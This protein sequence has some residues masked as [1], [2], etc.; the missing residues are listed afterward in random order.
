MLLPEVDLNKVLGV[1]TKN[2]SITML[3]PEVH[4]LPKLRINLVRL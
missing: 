4:Y 2:Y 3:L 1:D